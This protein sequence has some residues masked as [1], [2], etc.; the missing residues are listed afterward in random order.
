MPSNAK[1]SLTHQSSAKCGESKGLR[2]S[3]HQAAGSSR[4]YTVIADEH[5]VLVPEQRM[6]LDL[7]SCADVPPGTHKHTAS[8]SL[9]AGSSHCQ[10][11]LCSV[12]GVRIIRRT[13]DARPGSRAL[14]SM[15]WPPTCYAEGN[16]HIVELGFGIDVHP[17]RPPPLDPTWRLQVC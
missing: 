9:A 5:D 10:L 11:D 16:Q 7:V 8:R 6:V 1:C 2:S 17:A 15:F 14:D 3:R 12:C 13:R 4:N